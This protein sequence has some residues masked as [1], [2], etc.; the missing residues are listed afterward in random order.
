MRHRVMFASYIVNTAGMTVAGPSLLGRRDPAGAGR[1][2]IYLNAVLR[3]ATSACR[4]LAGM[5]FN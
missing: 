5:R 3:Q 1:H 2:A 4:G